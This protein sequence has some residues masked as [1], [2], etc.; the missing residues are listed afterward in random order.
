MSC[1]LLLYGIQRYYYMGYK[2]VL[3]CNGKNVVDIHE[4][5][6]SCKCCLL[7]K[8]DWLICFISLFRLTQ[9]GVNRAI[10][11]INL[12]IVNSHYANPLLALPTSATTAT[13]TAA[14]KQNASTVASIFEEHVVYKRLSSTRDFLY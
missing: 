5:K 4:I 3:V 13:A 8:G 11:Q 2:Q 10:D 12:H 7:F 14:D 1:H 9:H 6:M